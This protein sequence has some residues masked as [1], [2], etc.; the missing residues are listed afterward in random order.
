MVRPHNGHWKWLIQTRISGLPTTTS[1]IYGKVTDIPVAGDW[2]G[3]GSMDPGVVRRDGAS[4]QYRLRNSD[5][6]GRAD[7][8][9]QYGLSATDIPVVGDWDGNGTFTPAV[10]RPDGTRWQYL[11]RNS[12]T[13][14]GADI[15]FR[16]GR[17]ATDI[18]IVGDWDGNGT[19]TP[20]VVRPD[21]TSWQYRLRNSNTTG[22]ATVR[23]LYG[24]TSTDIPVTGD[25]T[26]NGIWS[27]G[28]V[29]ADGAS[30]QYMLRDSNTSGIPDVS[31]LFGRTA[32]D[33][34][35]AG[36]Y[37]ASDVGLTLRQWQATGGP[38]AADRYYGYPYSDPPA[39]TH[40]GP[41]AVD[42]LYFY[43]GQCTSWVAYRL[44]ELNAIAFTDYFGGM[45]LWGDAAAWGRH[46]RKL[47]IAVNS[48]PAV[49]SVAW[50]ASGH[51]AYVEKVSSPISVVISEMNYDTDNGFRLRAI[52]TA[53]GWPTRFIHI[54]DRSSGPVEPTGLAGCQASTS[55]TA[56]NSQ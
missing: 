41:C 14:G 39:C 23:F 18:P 34:P 36:A 47:K 11:L 8:I 26:G 24:Q 32:T 28:L 53:S 29:R 43:R 33:V 51:V 20:G 5:T 50:Y 7:V 37:P 54:A 31:F 45:G 6:A 40:G 2:T 13:S 52:T 46:A 10:V 22:S 1:F 44:S 17:T 4:W 21:G 27:P 15:S 16:Y 19:F 48:T 25:W 12:N 55:R 42:N 3:G 9:F 30:W 49:G 38:M 56:S 35:V